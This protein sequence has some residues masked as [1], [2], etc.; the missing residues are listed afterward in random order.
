MPVAQK[1][2]TIEPHVM[3]QSV[4]FVHA[5]CALATP[6]QPSN[7]ATLIANVRA[8]ALHF[9]FMIISLGKKVFRVRTLPLDA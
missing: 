6:L 4:S 1:L 5:A 8:I 3:L 7:P 2:Q 9:N